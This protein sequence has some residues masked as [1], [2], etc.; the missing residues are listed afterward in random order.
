MR[1]SRDPRGVS[2]L[3][4]WL[5]AIIAYPT[6]PPEAL[7]IRESR[8]REGEIASASHLRSRT[9]PSSTRPRPTRS[10]P[11]TSWPRSSS[12]GATPTGRARPGPW[13]RSPRRARRLSAS[14]ISLQTFFEREI[15][16]EETSEEVVDRL[17]AELHENKQDLLIN[18]LRPVFVDP[19]RSHD[20]IG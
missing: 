15:R 13:T 5:L 1:K 7:G 2:E 9:R 3:G 19:I 20:H 18:V 10:R 16:A 8:A 4:F 11:T 6:A 17:D 12:R 14:L